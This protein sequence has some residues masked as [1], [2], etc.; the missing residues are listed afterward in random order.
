[1]ESPT[2]NLNYYLQ[3]IDPISVFWTIVLEPVDSPWS[4]IISIS[5]RDLW[6]S[7]YIG[8]GCDLTC[9]R[10]NDFLETLTLLKIDIQRTVLL[11][12]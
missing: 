9:L 12:Y 3:I 2:F 5:M 10:S 4:K 1:M 7:I 6:L 11:L 8:D